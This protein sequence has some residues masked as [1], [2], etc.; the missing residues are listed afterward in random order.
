MWAQKSAWEL[1]PVTESR[2]SD[3]WSYAPDMAAFASGRAASTPASGWR[4]ALRRRAWQRAHV[5]G[6]H[7][8][9]DN[10]M[11]PAALSS[12]HSSSNAARASGGSSSVRQEA[13]SAAGQS[14]MQQLAPQQRLERLASDVKKWQS[15]NRRFQAMIEKIGTDA[16]TVAYREVLMRT[17]RDLA[18]SM[19]GLW[20][21]VSADVRD[22]PNVKDVPSAYARSMHA[23]GQRADVQRG[24]LNESKQRLA[25]KLQ[26]F[27]HAIGAERGASAGSTRGLQS[28]DG[29]RTG[30]GSS[31]AQAQ[32]QAE[33]Q[34]LA[35][36]TAEVYAA[37]AQE[38][39][40]EAA[41]I[42]QQSTE[43]R[44]IMQDLSVLVHGQS[45]QI[46]QLDDNVTVALHRTERGVEK[47]EQAAELQRA[48]PCTIQ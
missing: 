26:A 37:I 1:A 16:D 8:D 12:T 29:S 41:A 3:G 9:A 47:L 30:L 46:R 28:A 11:P 21:Q 36:G 42:A 5:N 22:A 10:C 31:Q 19:D 2:D 13:D 43:L 14:D 24:V 6:Q 25:A 45:E 23:L 34:L 40:E 20:K 38:R 7:S 17:Q 39:A 15:I 48:S 27:P 33:P 32:A 4:H 35:N 44:D 18:S